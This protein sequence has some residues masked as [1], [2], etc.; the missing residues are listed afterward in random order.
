MRELDHLTSQTGGKSYDT[1]AMK[2]SQAFAEIAGELR[3]LYGV[4]YQSTNKVRDGAFRKI[5]IQPARPGL[6]VRARAG[7]YAK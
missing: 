1:H 7:Y 2:V 3:S 5:V 4:A 6:T